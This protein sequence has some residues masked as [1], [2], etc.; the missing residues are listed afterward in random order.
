MAKRQ[1]RPENMSEERLKY[2]Q[3][4][5]RKKLLKMKEKAIQ[6]KKQQK[7]EKVPTDLE[8][9]TQQYQ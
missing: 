2:I 3:D 4:R 5:N 9:T 6:K 7:E 8:I 1:Q